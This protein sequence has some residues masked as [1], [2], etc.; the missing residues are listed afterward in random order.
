[1]V[2]N[3]KIKEAV[4]ETGDPLQ[5]SMVEKAGNGVTGK[6]PALVGTALK[7]ENK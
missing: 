1:L 4:L 7:W 2:L 3:L 6:V 5:K